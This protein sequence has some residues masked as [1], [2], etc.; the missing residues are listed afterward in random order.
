M[1]LFGLSKE[2][3]EGEILKKSLILNTFN[4]SLSKC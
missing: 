1:G 2:P 4:P 3:K